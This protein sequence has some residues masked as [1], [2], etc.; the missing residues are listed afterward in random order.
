MRR[1][2]TYQFIGSRCKY[3]TF[4]LLS[5]HKSYMN[6]KTA[7]I[8]II[9][10]ILKAVLAAQPQSTF[11][12]SITHQYMER[13]SLSKKQLEGLYSKAQKVHGISPGKM[14]TLQAVILK[15]HAKHRSEKPAIK[16][17]FVKDE[18]AGKL[19]EDIL[20]KYPQHKRVIFLKNKYDK[21]DI[22]SPAEMEE[23]QR[24]HKLLLKK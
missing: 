5:V 2:T 13:G 7:D 18:K 20:E 11:M 17:M 8:D 14:A 4:L 12:Q 16:P 10:D 19:I 3:G 9:F 21:N 6:K 24:F 22:I 15:K 23:L 1:T